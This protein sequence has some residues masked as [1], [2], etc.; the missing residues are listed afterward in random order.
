M[1]VRAC[2]QAFDALGNRPQM[3]PEKLIGQT[4]RDK[5]Q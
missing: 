3:L 5:R 4:H 2:C 1:A